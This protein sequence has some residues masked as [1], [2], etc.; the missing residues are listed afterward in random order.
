M[1]N[2]LPSCIISGMRGTGKF[3]WG[4]GVR[5][6]ILAFFGYFTIQSELKFFFNF[7]GNGVG[8]LTQRLS[9]SAHV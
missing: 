7:L 6:K 9:R 5:D 1:E 3:S 8:I 4:Q 2:S